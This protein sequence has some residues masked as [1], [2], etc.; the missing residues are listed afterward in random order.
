MPMEYIVPSLRIDAFTNMAELDILEE[1]LM[2]LTAL[3]ED[4][5]I[6]NFH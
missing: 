1:R 2:Q 3:E 6:V 5:F 4:Q